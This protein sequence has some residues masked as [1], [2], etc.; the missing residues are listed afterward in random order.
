MGQAD[1]GDDAAEV[2]VG[3]VE[4]A[5]DVDDAAIV[6]AE[7]GEVLEG[8]DGGEPLDE[9]VV[10]PAHPEHEGVLFAGA[11]DAEDHEG[12]LLPFADELRDHLGRVLEVGDDGDDGVAGGLEEGVHRGADVAEVAGVDDDLDAG[13]GGGDAF[14]DGDGGV[15]GGVVDEDV[16]V[17]EL[18]D[19]GHD[20]AD[21]V[22][23]LLYVGFFV[24]AGG[25]DADELAHGV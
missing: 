9:A 7:A 12:A 15:G 14:E 22:I 2:W 13:V 11:L 23:E 1:L 4:G 17:V 5:R 6:E 20:G 8:L 21:A 19:G 10:L 24:E 18:R 16:F 3:V 25:D